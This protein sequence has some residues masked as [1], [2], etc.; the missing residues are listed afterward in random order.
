MGMPNWPKGQAN[1]LT[2]PGSDD[3][4]S[5]A[6]DEDGDAHSQAPQAD[7][8]RRRKRKTRSI[9]QREDRR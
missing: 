2:L 3:I 5:P 1:S 6:P 8:D 4:V 9:V 7:G